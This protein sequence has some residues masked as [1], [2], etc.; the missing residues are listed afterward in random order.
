MKIKSF[1]LLMMS[2]F[3]VLGLVGCNSQAKIDEADTERIT[4]IEEKVD[5]LFNKEKTDIVDFTKEQVEEIDLLLVEEEGNEFSEDNALRIGSVI[6]YLSQALEMQGFEERVVVLFD[7]EGVLV[8]DASIEGLDSEVEMFK[9]ETAFYDRLVENINVAENQLVT[10][11]EVTD[12][13]DGLFSEGKVKKDVT[14]KQEEEATKLIGEVSNKEVKDDLLVKL[15]DVDASLTKKEEQIALAKKEEEQKQEQARQKQER[16][17]NEVKKQQ[18]AQESNGGKASSSSNSSS[19]KQTAN[20]NQTSKKPSNTTTS[21]K[22]KGTT[23]SKPKTDK[24]STS[25]GNSNNSGGTDWDAV[26]DFWNNAECKKT[27]SGDIGDG[28]TYENYECN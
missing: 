1:I 18:V 8:K 21:S 20:S 26:G 15:V 25:S 19:K 4:V 27:E 24:G 13:V 10:I 12:Y 6:L 11:N 9:D 5:A 23:T 2:V 14:R 16:K 7:D 28:G 22:D 17:Q 3:V